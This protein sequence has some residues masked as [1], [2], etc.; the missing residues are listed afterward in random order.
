MFENFC[1]FKALVENATGN[2]TKVPCLDNGGEYIDKYFIDFCAK[3]GIKREWT[4]SY[5]PQ[6]NV[7][8]ERKS[9][10]IVGAAKAM[11]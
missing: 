9:R 3:E 7:V 10:T 8:M 1:N 11:L 5:N 4:T 2:E 6:Q